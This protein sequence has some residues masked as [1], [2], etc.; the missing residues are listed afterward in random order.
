ML[1]AATPDMGVHASAT[2]T[3]LVQFPLLK[4]WNAD[5]TQTVFL[6]TTSP[7]AVGYC[8]SRAAQVMVALLSEKEPRSF[9]G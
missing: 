2:E 3:R 6:L 4:F 9:P 8:A 1:L 7:W 5:L